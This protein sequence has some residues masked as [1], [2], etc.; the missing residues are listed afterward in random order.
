MTKRSDRPGLGSLGS[1]AVTGISLL[2]VS[3]VAAAVGVVIARKFGRSDETDGLLAAY[4]VFVVIVIAAQ[5]MRV[6]VLPD[7]ARARAEGRLAGELSGMVLALVA[8]VVPLVLVTET[9]TRPL[10]YVLTGG[11]SEVARDTAADALRWMIVAASAHLFAALVASALASLDDYGTSAVAYAAGSLSGLALILATIDSSGIVAVAWGMTTN[12]AVV[13]GVTSAALALR[14]LR[15]RMPPRAATPTG[16]PLLTR[17][18]S[19]AVAASLPLTLQLLYVVCLPFA[20]R[21]GTGSATSFVY[22]YLAASALVQVTAGSLGLVTSVPLSRTSF[23]PEAVSRHVVAGTWI[24]LTIIGA[25]AGVF[26]LAG[27]HV[28]EAVLGG[29]YGGHVGS[30]V[31]NLIVAFSV[32]VVAAVGLTVAFPLMFLVGRTRRLPWIALAALA[33]QVPLAWAASELFG[34]TGLALAL[35]ISTFV[36]FAALLR[37]LEALHESTA[38][39]VTAAALVG[40][41]TAVAFGVPSLVLGPALSALLGLVVYGGIVALLRPRRLRASWAYLRAIG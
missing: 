16:E 3:A 20:G 40:S 21:L 33:L 28:V 8:V 5:A 9:A 17:V 41:L 29:A 22:A 23:T 35:G 32:W 2:I 25:A 13:L 38:G 31:G 36:V 15:E 4:G 7:L 24:A 19:F 26:A 6:A 34:L 12:G 11:G 27:G 37:E 18:G 10:A 30:A 1:G 39:V 14:A